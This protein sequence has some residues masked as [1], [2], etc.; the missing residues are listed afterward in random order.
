MER[1]PAM[2]EARRRTSQ[3]DTAAASKA[4]AAE[5]E[6]LFQEAA[7]HQAAGR[8]GAAVAGYAQAIALRPLDSRAYNNLGVALRAQGKPHAALASYRRARALKPEDPGLHSNMG[9]V[10]RTLGRL[11][12]AAASIRRSVELRPEASDPWRNL[13]LVL[14]DLG[15]LDEAIDCFDRALALRPGHVDILWDRTYAR[16]LAGDL[17]RGFAGYEVRWGL[18]EAAPRGFK[19][20][21]WDGAALDGRTI[22]LYAE[23]GYG[24]TIQFARYVPMVAARGGR[25]LLECKAEMRALLQ[26]LPGVAEFV[27]KGDDLPAF[28]VQ[29][30]LASLPWLFGTRLDTVPGE[31][32]YLTTPAGPGP[33]IEAAPGIKA[34]VG[35]AWGGS[36]THKNDSNRS[37]SLTQ[38]LG[39]VERPDLAFY[40][41]QKGA[42]AK[43]L[44]TTGAG[45]LIRDLDPHMG[46][47]ADTARLVDALDLVITVDTSVAHLAGALARPVWILLPFAPDWRWMRDREDSPWYPTARLFRQERA[48]DWPGLFERVGRALDGLVGE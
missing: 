21:M 41:L 38:F 48:G 2:A 18:S 33:R 14:R 23:Q 28:D 7:A 42:R 17:E 4:R 1:A 6:R 46:D 34:R 19:E 37:L 11:E 3:K 32:P 16:L 9:N 5:A 45:A 25:V 10:L 36:P 8:L 12:E 30:P 35:I 24:D 20:P 26:H 47:F 27:V 40:S 15:A 22:L 44:A 43:E 13:G 31:V 29:A 39:L